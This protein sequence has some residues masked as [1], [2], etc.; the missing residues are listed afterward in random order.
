MKTREQEFTETNNNYSTAFRT[1]LKSGLSLTECITI[2][3]AIM[4]MDKTM[5]DVEEVK[6]T[7]D[8]QTYY[9]STKKGVCDTHIFST[10]E[11]VISVDALKEFASNA[12]TETLLTV[13]GIVM[14]LL[15]IDSTYA[16]NS[17][18]DHNEK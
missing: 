2:R 15:N 3:D 14:K 16:F 9:K 13:L 7:T 18:E 10:E 5:H 6:F 11:E 12:S 4:A 1:L 17:T 8:P